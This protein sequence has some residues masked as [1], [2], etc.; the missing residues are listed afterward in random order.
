[1]YRAYTAQKKYGVVSSEIR[2]LMP[3]PLQA[4]KLLARYFS[5]SSSSAK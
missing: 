3:A 2:D 5:Q 1:M 4:V